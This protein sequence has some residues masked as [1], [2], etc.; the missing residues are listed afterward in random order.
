MTFLNPFVLIGLLA[1]SI[2][3]II[4]L[5]NL[6]RL[7]VIEFSSIQFLK[8][9]QKNKMRKLKIKQILLLILRTLVIIFLVLAFSRPTIREVNLAGLGSEVKNTIII[10]IDDTPSMS[11]ADKRGEYFLQ[12]KK[13]ASQ[14][15]EASEEGDEIYLLK[16]SEL[17]PQKT[18][19]NHTSKTLALREIQNLELSDVSRIFFDVF[20][21]T[22]K[23][24]E[25]S[26]NLSKEVFVL[27]DFQETNFSEDDLIN[28]KLDRVIDRNTRVFFFKIGEK[29]AYNISID[30]LNLINRIFEINKAVT[31][32]AS[33]TNHSDENGTNINSDLFFNE[34]KVA[35]KG[36]DLQKNSSGIF[37][38]TG[39]L[40]EHGFILSRLEIEDDDLIKDNVRYFNF[41]VPEKVK[42]LLVSENPN[43]LLFVN[44]VLSQTL[45]DNSEPIFSTTTTTSQF[46]NSYKLENFDVLIVS[47]PEKIYNINILKD[48][49]SKG[50][51]AVLIPGSNSAPLAFSK[52][53]EELGLNS[54]NGVSGSKDS[55]TTFTR[56]KEI[57]FNHP[58][59]YGI[60]SERNQRQIESPKIFYSFNYK[61]TLKGKEIITLENGNA[62]LCEEKVDE[63]SVIIFTS[64]FDLNWNELPIKPIFV[65][66]INRIALYTKSSLKNFSFIAGDDVKISLGRSYQ[67]LKL[68]HPN[69]KESVITETDNSSGLVNAGRLSEAG[70]YKLL[71][72]NEIVGAISVNIDPRESN[73][74]KLEE[75][76]LKD[77]AKKSFPDG[78]L[79][80]L[81]AE[82]NPM[83]VIKQERYGTELWKLFLI[84]A[85]ISLALE[86]FI[87]RA[88]KKDLINLEQSK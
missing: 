4:H 68:I 48:Y 57:D 74:T 21:T 27:T 28:L 59:F 24:L 73:L 40:K 88:S 32:S 20:V 19:F 16:F 1:A 87:A 81:N 17:N 72:G 47:S 18:E 13:I 9:M 56:F 64:A 84:L 6:R 5:L 63:G 7:K 46:F 62:F 3:I 60:F 54:V 50:G 12:A 71:S 77:F 22:A 51:V 11:V 75:N 61:P 44:L 8:E 15:L 76:K 66:L 86:M 80:I 79:K 23:I 69:G 65:P 35:Q 85:I 39:Q 53:L 43:D 42:V 14:I 26:K 38:F 31:I 49:I 67:N 29:N 58:F 41:Y 45:D 2:P 52:V 70:N 10:I 36:I 25:H 78:K 34:K 83:E 37:S 55:K 30:S 82:A 33:I